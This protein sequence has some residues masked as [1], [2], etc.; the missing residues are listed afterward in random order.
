MRRIPIIVASV[1]LVVSLGVAAA[2]VGR[3]GGDLL[4]ARRW[5]S[6]LDADS[7]LVWA[8]GSVVV[9]GRLQLSQ[10]RALGPAVEGGGLT[11]VAASPDGRL[12]LGTHG[13]ILNV[14]DPATGIIENLGKPV[15]SECPT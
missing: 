1:C 4:A 13:A 7:D 10:V 6:N 3:D 9:D 12:Y 2:A 5:V 14:Y 8:E 11:S 15:P